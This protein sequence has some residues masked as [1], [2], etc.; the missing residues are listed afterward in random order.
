[1]WQASRPQTDSTTTL[2]PFRGL[3]GSRLDNF[4][5]FVPF[6]TSAVLNAVVCEAVGLK[7]LQY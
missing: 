4:P 5:P 1:M 6:L 7:V 2:E 3:F